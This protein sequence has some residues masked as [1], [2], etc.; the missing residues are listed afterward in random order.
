MLESGKQSLTGSFRHH[1]SEVLSHQW[2]PSE[3][4]LPVVDGRRIPGTGK[5]IGQVTIIV[6]EPIRFKF[7]QP[8]SSAKM[9]TIFGCWPRVTGAHNTKTVKTKMMNRINRFDLGSEGD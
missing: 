2:E 4:A 8:Q 5:G 9:N 7:P 3:F 6:N 1:Q